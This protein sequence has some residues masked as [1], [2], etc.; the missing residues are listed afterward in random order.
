MESVQY[1]AALV[2]AKTIGRTSKDKL[3]QELGFESLQ[4]RKWFG[5]LYFHTNEEK[6]RSHCISSTEFL[7]HLSHILQENLKIDPR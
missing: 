7:R 1:D 6:V 2:I 4:S 3:Y 5:N